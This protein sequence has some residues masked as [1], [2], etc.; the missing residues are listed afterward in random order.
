MHPVQVNRRV[1]W[2]DPTDGGWKGG[3]ELLVVL[4]S[5]KSSLV[6]LWPTG[7]LV[8][9]DYELLQEWPD[10]KPDPPPSEEKKYGSDERIIG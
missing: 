6:R 7:Q 5:D 10:R 1:R 4:K 2:I 9:V 8:I 3:E